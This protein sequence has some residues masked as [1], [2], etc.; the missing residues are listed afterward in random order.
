MYRSISVRVKFILHLHETAQRTRGSRVRR[1]DVAQL[2][3]C[4]I[5]TPLTHVRFPGT[6]RDCSPREN[7]QCR[8]S[9]GVR[10]PP[11]TIA[12]ICICAHVKDPVVHV[13]VRWIMETLKIPSMHRRLGSATLSQLA[14]SGEGNAN[15]PWEKSHWDNTAVK[16]NNKKKVV[17]RFPLP[18]VF[19][20]SKLNFFGDI[21]A[22]CQSI[23]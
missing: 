9:Y 14:F 6:A 12:C 8:L 17:L 23:V 20:T 22:L 21:S 16:S 11:C 5:G 15:F 18:W 13:R 1:G 7:F 19:K 4:R 10:T 2:V 3:E